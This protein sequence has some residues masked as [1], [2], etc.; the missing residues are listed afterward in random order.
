MAV[1][2]LNIVVML[3]FILML[4][5]KAVKAA[6]TCFA[7]Q[8]EWSDGERHNLTYT[9]KNGPGLKLVNVDNGYAKEGI[10]VTPII[11]VDETFNRLVASWNV[12]TPDDTYAVVEAKVKIKG[13]N[14]SDWYTMGTWGTGIESASKSYP[15]QNEAGFFAVD[16]DTFVITH[17]A[18]ADQYQLKISLVSPTGNK[19]PYLYRLGAVAYKDVGSKKVLTKFFTVE[20][21]LSVPMKSQMDEDDAIKSVV[22]SPTCLAMVFSYWGHDEPVA[23]VARNVF[24]NGAKIY[25]NWSFNVAYA[26]SLGYKSHV[27]YY[28]DIEGI[29]LQILKGVPVIASIRFKEGELTNAPIKSS[30]GHL[31]LVRGF[32]TVAGIEYVI[33]NDP[34]AKGDSVRREYSVRE[35]EKVWRGIV[36]IIEPKTDE[37]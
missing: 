5:S 1:K 36:Y 35:F 15:S 29:K 24:D 23:S 26:G 28:A 25:G 2:T 11:A 19:T 4:A 17:P 30:N 9:E 6:F 7:D 33:V 3:V 22:C 12:L 14:W 18:G 27:D 32:K 16:I 10:F 31:V 34:A 20:K 21:E 8:A 13:D 37:N